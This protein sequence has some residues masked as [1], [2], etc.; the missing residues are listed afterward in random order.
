MS[1]V[2]LA[3]LLDL[4]A[5]ER[6]EIAQA[7]WDS[8]AARPESVPLTEAQREELDRRLLEYEDNPDAGE[9]WESVKR[10][11]DSE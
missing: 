6:L 7:I 2:S 11:L 5:D 8:I 9:T 3:D 4:P 10:S 1:R